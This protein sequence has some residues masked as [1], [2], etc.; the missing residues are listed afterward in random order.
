MTKK[1]RQFLG[2]NTVKQSVAAP[3]DTKLSD[4]TANNELSSLRVKALIS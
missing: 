4:A 1:G 2:E 3:C